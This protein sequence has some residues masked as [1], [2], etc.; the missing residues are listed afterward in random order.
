MSAK[1]IELDRVVAELNIT[2]SNGVNLKGE[3]DSLTR[4]IDDTDKRVIWLENEQTT[5]SQLW[6][7]TA[8]TISYSDPIANN[9]ALN[10]YA[11]E[12]ETKR[13]KLSDFTVQFRHVEDQLFKA[14]ESVSQSE[15][16]HHQLDSLVKLHQQQVEHEQKTR[17][18][19]QRQLEKI[20]SET[21]QQRR[22][23]ISHI[24][25]C[26]YVIEPQ[27]DLFSWI[28]FKQEDFTKWQ[29]NELRF[30]ESQKELA[31]LQSNLAVHQNRLSDIEQILAVENK[32]LSVQ[33]RKLNDL[34]DKR[35]EIFGERVVE[36]ERQRSL[37]ALAQSEQELA[38][39]QKNFQ[40]VQ[41]EQKAIEGELKIINANLQAAKEQAEKQQEQWNALLEQSQFSSTQ[42]F[43]LALL[44]H[45]ERT[46][47]TEM[48]QTLA[49]ALERAQ[50][51]LD[52]TNKQCEILLSDKQGQEYQKADKT[53]V[54]QRLVELKE[55]IRQ[56]TK[57]EGELANELQSDQRR[58]QEQQALFDEIEK[59]TASYEDIQY[60]HSLI[61]SSSGDKF[62]KFAQGLTLDNL[63]YLANRQLSRLHGRYQ[64]QRSKGEGLELSV[65]DTWQGDVVRDTKT[66]SGGESFLVSLA[67]A[68]G[69]SDLVSHKTSIDSLFLDEGFGTLD[70]ETLDL[71]LDALDSLNA[72]G[73][74]IGVISHVEAM[75]E[76]IPVQLKVSKKSG[77]GI[78][79]L[80]S[81]Y[82]L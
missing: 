57:R 69:L 36:Q 6:Q 9:Q 79:E 58:R 2:Q 29:T 72:S 78:S 31:A 59:Q 52:S 16:A 4:H 33:E 48:K 56:V 75:K 5:L 63:V 60:L 66:L 76:R 50:A 26:G 19:A 55:L 80:D 35:Q 7:K 22:S 64:L 38:N 15:Q 18:E 42:A 65:V 54:E 47:L 45:E 30:N 32:Q 51:I 25:D 37:H 43:E 8:I 12:F 81:T 71:A 82:R 28:E 39:A 70:A 1:Q 10:T 67:L 24:S 73:K 17:D 46:R 53:E 23:L 40:Q 13:N 44:D 20:D 77:L 11:L 27:T 49:M 68:L 62:R 3:I 61:G 21:E 34:V 41:Q 14:R 74:M